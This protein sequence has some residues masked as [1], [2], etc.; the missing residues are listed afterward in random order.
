VYGRLRF[1]PSRQRQ[2]AMPVYC[3]SSRFGPAREAHRAQSSLRRI[4]VQPRR[5][6]RP[7]EVWAIKKPRPRA[8]PLPVGVINLAN[9]VVQRWV[10]SIT[11]IFRREIPRHACYHFTWPLAAV[12][13]ETGLIERS[14]RSRGALRIRRLGLDSRLAMGFAMNRRSRLRGRG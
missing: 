2:E 4:P 5:L 3:P 10:N 13:A 11:P 12:K 14:S 8:I 1:D 6:H 7:G 9:E